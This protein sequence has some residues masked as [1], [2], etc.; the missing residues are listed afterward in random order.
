[1]AKGA[2][3]IN[4]KTSEERNKLK[5]EAIKTL[6]EKYDVQI[7]VV[8]GHRIQIIGIAQKLSDVNQVECIIAQKDLDENG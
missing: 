2:I 1:M 3:A 4:C 5:D 8:R 7:P 6:G